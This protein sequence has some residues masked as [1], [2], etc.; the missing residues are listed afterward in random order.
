MNNL[1]DTYLNF[2]ERKMKKYLKIIF[3]TNYD[4]N[5]VNEF[6]SFHISYI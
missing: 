3:N 5:I 2:T 1:M 4:E 6:L